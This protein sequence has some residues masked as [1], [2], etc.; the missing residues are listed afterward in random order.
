MFETKEYQNDASLLKLLHDFAMLNYHHGGLEDLTQKVLGVETLT[1]EKLAN[2]L[3][4]RTDK[5]IKSLVRSALNNQDYFKAYFLAKSSSVDIHGMIPKLSDKKIESE[6]EKFFQLYF[7]TWNNCEKGLIG[8]AEHLGLNFVY[9]MRRQDQIVL[10]SEFD[11]IDHLKFGLG[12]N[13]QSLMGAGDYSPIGICVMYFDDREKKILLEGREN[14][15]FRVRGGPEALPQ[16]LIYGFENMG[17]A[18]PSEILPSTASTTFG[19]GRFMV[20]NNSVM[21]FG[22]DQRLGN[23]HGDLITECLEEG[24]ALFNGK[25]I[26]AELTQLPGPFF[27]ESTGSGLL[28]L[29][30]YTPSQAQA[31]GR[32]K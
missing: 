9:F 20:V 27:L 28:G 31:C 26:G 11:P 24:N 2:S 21:I 14:P 18:N 17:Y 1:G 23:M 12:S 30:N 25:Y 8:K 32:R 22:H 29:L 4:K 15:H 6:K 3:R 13:L 19:A 5:Y 7:E 16:E 10:A